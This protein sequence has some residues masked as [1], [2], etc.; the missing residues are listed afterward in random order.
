MGEVFEGMP[1]WSIE[2][3]LYNAK[4][5]IIAKYLPMIEIPNKLDSSKPIFKQLRTSDLDTKQF[6]DLI[7][8]TCKD[9]GIPPPDDGRVKSMFDEY[10][11]R[12]PQ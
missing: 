10:S 3:G 11:K 6:A 8:V 7:T 12:Y 9:F 2:E 4:E 5:A 1:E